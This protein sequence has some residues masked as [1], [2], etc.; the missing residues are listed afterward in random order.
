MSAEINRDS[1][2]G[3]WCQSG[4]DHIFF[5]ED[6]LRGPWVVRK[7]KNVQKLATVRVG[8]WPTVALQSGK[9]MGQKAGIQKACYQTRG[10]NA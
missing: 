4:D 3:C 8:E 6:R 5:E 10:K 2:S 9:R 1:G 7:G